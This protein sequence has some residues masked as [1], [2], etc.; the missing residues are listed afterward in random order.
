MNNACVIV[1]QVCQYLEDAPHDREG[2]LIYGVLNMIFNDVL[3]P[4]DADVEIIVLRFYFNC[5]CNLGLDAPTPPSC[6]KLVDKPK[7]TKLVRVRLCC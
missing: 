3:V 7:Q 6:S 1:V 2:I 5:Y 4:S